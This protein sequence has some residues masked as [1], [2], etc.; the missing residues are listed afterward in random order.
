M[1]RPMTAESQ[2]EADWRPPTGARYV[3]TNGPGVIVPAE[4][5]FY[6]PEESSRWW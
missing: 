5:A 4:H 1:I 6:D 2:G 3:G